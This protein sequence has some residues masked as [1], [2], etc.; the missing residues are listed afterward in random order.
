MLTTLPAP[1]GACADLRLPPS[2]LRIWIL[3]ARAPEPV[4]CTHRAIA[5]QFGIDP[6]HA[7]RSIRA[8]VRAGYVERQRIRGEHYRYAYSVSHPTSVSA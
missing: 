2:A 8:L 1:T 4:G 6:K 5:E 7:G 3:L